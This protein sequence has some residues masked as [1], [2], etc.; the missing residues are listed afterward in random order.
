MLCGQRSCSSVD[1][2]SVEEKYIQ[3][4]Y[5]RYPKYDS[6]TFL[7]HPPHI[8]SSVELLA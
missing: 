3:K 8:Y 5:Q 7:L 2:V 1:V 6:A 4:R